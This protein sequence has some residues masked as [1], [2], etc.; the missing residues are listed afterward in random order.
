MPNFCNL[1]DKFFSIS[2]WK[3]HELTGFFLANEDELNRIKCVTISMRFDAKAGAFNF[4]KL[5]SNPMRILNYVIRL[6]STWTY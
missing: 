5:Y 3:V 2:E 1:R 4:N 6:N